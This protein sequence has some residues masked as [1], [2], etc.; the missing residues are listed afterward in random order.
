MTGIILGSG[1]HKMVEE[2]QNPEVLYENNET[3][4]KKMVIKANFEGKEIL[5]FKGRSHIYEGAKEKDIISNILLSKNYNVKNLI[6]TNAAGGVN[7]YY[8]TTDLMLINSHINNSLVKFSGLKP[9]NNIYN[10]DLNKR[11][12]ELAIKNK[13]LLRC[14]VYFSLLGP[15][16]ETKS[17]I[18]ILKKL[19]VDAVG[20]STVPEVLFSKLNNINFI[21]ISCITNL[22]KENPTGILNHSEVEETG[23]KAY[24]KFLKLIKLLVKE[25]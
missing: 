11:I 14:G 23:N 18:R 16:Y 17:D 13:I 12:I 19:R 24:N 3:F 10:P 1:L 6:I 15:V 7:N 5:V 4:H 21:G 25:L 8:K 22:V 2:L 20:M 9:V